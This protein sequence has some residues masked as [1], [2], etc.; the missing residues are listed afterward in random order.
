M[1]IINIILL[2]IVGEAPTDDTALPV[3]EGEGEAMDTAEHSGSGEAA[4]KTEDDAPS[5]MLF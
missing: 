4:L 3:A 5:G 1:Q 2:F